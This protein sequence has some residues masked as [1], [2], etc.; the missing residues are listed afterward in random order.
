MTN[1][2][3]ARLAV[4]VKAAKAFGAKVVPLVN[5]TRYNTFANLSRGGTTFVKSGDSGECFAL[6]TPSGRVAAVVVEGSDGWNARKPAD[7]LAHPAKEF[8]L[9]AHIFAD[10]RNLAGCVKLAL[11]N[12]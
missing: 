2:N 5:E 1:T 11:E 10:A 12:Y 9:R 7:E 6:V 4:A 3:K 8:A